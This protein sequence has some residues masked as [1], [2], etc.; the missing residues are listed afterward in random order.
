M[1]NPQAPK[2]KLPLKKIL[3]SANVAEHLDSTQLEYVGGCVVDGYNRDE[4]SRA[5]WLQRNAEALK[6]ALQIAEHKTFPWPKCSNVKFP[7]LTIAALQFLARVAILT[8]GRHLVKM[9]V[10]G[11][12]PKGEKAARGK[13][14]STHMSLQLLESQVNWVDHDEQV[15]LSAAIMGS[16][17]KKTYNDAVTGDNISEHVPAGQIV[18]D[19]FT[20][21][22]DRANRITHLI[23]MTPNT[24]EERV[25]R[26][27]FLKMIDGPDGMPVSN[28]MTAAQDDVAGKSRPAESEEC[29]ILEQHCWMDL[30]GDGYEEPYIV[31]VR[32]DTRQCLRIVARF[33]DEGDVYR[34]NDG[35]IRQLTNELAEAGDDLKRRSALEKQIEALETA[36]DN[37]IIRIDPQK[38]FTRYVFIPSPDGGVYGLGM[39]ALLGPI[40]SS[41]DTLINQMIDGGTMSV[42]AGGFL[43]RGVKMKAGTASFSPFEWKTVDS[44]G[45]DLKNNMVPIPVREPS[46]VLFQLLGMLVQYGEKISGA[47]DIMTGVAPGQNT[48]A[49]TSRNTVEQ[50]MMLFSGIYARMYRAFR[51]EL[52]KMYS[53]NKLYIKQS[54]RFYDL[55]KGEDALIAPTDYDTASLRIF[56]AASP[57]AVSTTQRKAKADML[58]QRAGGAPGYDKALVERKWLEAHEY[59]D[60]D[61][62]YRPQEI[63][64]TPNPKVELEKAKI[65]QKAKEHQDNFQLEVAQMKSDVMLTEAKISELQAKAE[66]HLSQAKGVETG[67]YIAIIEAQIGAAKA[68]REGLIKALDLL[69]NHEHNQ[70]KLEMEKSNGD[71]GS[72][73]KGMGAPPGNA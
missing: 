53:L 40:N 54:P 36:K 60:I 46:G 13:R 64:P 44:A 20:K 2:I 4:S 35:K 58:L 38:Y 18:L 68:Q 49:E 52:K 47:T 34:L 3:E 63:Q 1:D 30:D 72:G 8:K 66:L 29:D 31:S 25:R 17:F 26:G 70:K 56:P 11:A 69:S 41:V 19:Y 51:E 65:E 16:A 57:E 32:R 24:I 22:I 59:E 55:A 7:L 15:K 71:N 62:I 37:K 33:F 48:P 73:S 6:L 5:P 43:G 23:P 14:I 39:G 61:Q 42:T 9:D 12:D 50:G 27:L 10:I 45:A 28:V 21:D 67:H